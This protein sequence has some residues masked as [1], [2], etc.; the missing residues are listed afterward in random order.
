MSDYRI[1]IYRKYA[2]NMQDATAVFDKAF[3]ECWGIAYDTFLKGWLPEKKDALS[4]IWLAGVGFS[5][6]I[7]C[8]KGWD[9]DNS[10]E[11]RFIFYSG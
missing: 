9:F 10:N 5:K 8:L 3:A 6:K 1:R 4:L 11:W 2:S 7:M